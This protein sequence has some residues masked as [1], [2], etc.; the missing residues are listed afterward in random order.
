MRVIFLKDVPDVAKEGEVKEVADGYGRNFLLPRKLAVLA[1]SSTLKNLEAHRQTEAQQRMRSEAQVETIAERLQGL[2]L[3][4]K[5]RA[6]AQGRLYGS[7]TAA[8]IAKEIQKLT[9][10]EVDRRKMELEEPIRQ[11]GSYE[12]TIR[13]PGGV[14]P[15]IRVVVE[16]ETAL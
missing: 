10:A 12:V 16:E 14:S 11:L 4:L 6:G 3:T 9:G 13:L 1:S 2:S 15:R 7:V 8:D 5:A